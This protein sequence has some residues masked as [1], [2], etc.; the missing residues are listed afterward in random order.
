M[1]S[2][3]IYQLKVTLAY[4]KPVIWRR[5]LVASNTLLPDLHKVLQITMGWENAHLNQFIHQDKYYTASNPL[6]FFTEDESE[7]DGD[8]DQ[9][10]LNDLLINE[11]DAMIYEYDFGDGWTHKI[12]FRNHT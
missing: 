5:I 6:G 9:T 12:L 4:S 10:H 2:S 3:N 11:K 7:E 1:S 8:Y